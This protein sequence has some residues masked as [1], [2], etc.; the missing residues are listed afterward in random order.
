MKYTPR[1]RRMQ[2]LG[3][4]KHTDTIALNARASVSRRG[5]SID[6]LASGEQTYEGGRMLG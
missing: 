2:E 4:L 5:V 1:H 6:A 3:T